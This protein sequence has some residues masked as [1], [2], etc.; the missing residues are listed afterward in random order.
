MCLALGWLF[1]CFCNFIIFF[2]RQQLYWKVWCTQV[3]N[4]D[5]ELFIKKD[6]SLKKIVRIT[7]IFVDKIVI[8]NVTTQGVKCNPSLQAVNGSSRATSSHSYQHMDCNPLEA[9]LWR[10]SWVWCYESEFLWFI[11]FFNFFFLIL[12]SNSFG[13]ILWEMIT[14]RKPYDDMPRSNA[15]TV[16]WAVYNGRC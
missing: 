8:L 7:I 3:S 16:M 9:H 11:I 5:R 12:W 14:R 4:I 10:M 2:F 13:V 1:A 6:F 15:F